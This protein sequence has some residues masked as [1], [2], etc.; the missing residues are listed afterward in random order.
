V[1]VAASAEPTPGCQTAANAKRLSASI[2]LA[3]PRD[4]ACFVSHEGLA[5]SEGTLA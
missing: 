5:S 1:I 4:A 3:G 2:M